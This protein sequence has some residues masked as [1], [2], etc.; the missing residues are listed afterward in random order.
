M[1][2]FYKKRQ[3]T[4]RDSMLEITTVVIE[5]CFD[6]QRRQLVLRV[7]RYW[8]MTSILKS[9]R[10]MKAADVKICQ[11]LMMDTRQRFDRFSSQLAVVFVHTLFQWF[12][13]LRRAWTPG[14][15]V[16]KLPL[17][18]CLRYITTLFDEQGYW[19]ILEIQKTPW[20]HYGSGFARLD[21]EELGSRHLATVRRA[22]WSSTHESSWKACTWDHNDRLVFTTHGWATNRSPWQRRISIGW[23]SSRLGNVIRLKMAIGIG[24]YFTGHAQ[25]ETIFEMFGFGEK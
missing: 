23:R 21:Q 24:F 15:M 9:G 11:V 19:L 18:F 6:I 1:V 2:F 17:G 14:K 25:G 16:I 8:D 4:V 13:Q 20:D 5:Y 10:T 7:V 12:W 22:I 3:T